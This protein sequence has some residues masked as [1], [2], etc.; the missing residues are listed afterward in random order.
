LGETSI[1]ILEGIPMHNIDPLTQRAWDTGQAILKLEAD[2]ARILVNRGLLV[3]KFQREQMWE[4][5][6]CNTFEEWVAGNEQL[7]IDQLKFAAQFVNVFTERFRIDDPELLI[8]RT[9]KIGSKTEYK[10]VG[11]KKAGY[12]TPLAERLWS[13]VVGQYEIAD[14]NE[15]PLTKWG[16]RFDMADN[17]PTGPLLEQ[18]DAWI[19][20]HREVSFIEAR[21]KCLELLEKAAMLSYSELKEH[22]TAHPIA[23]TKRNGN[24]R[25][26][27]TS[28]Y[29]SIYKG[30]TSVEALRHFE[31][32]DNMLS[33]Y[34]VD[35]YPGE[36]IGMTFYRIRDG[37]T[38]E[39]EEMIEEWEG[40]DE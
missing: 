39:H 2:D 20:N 17:R 26:S 7:N 33:Y 28:V 32:V 10:P 31:T 16:M 12:I 24:H 6:D 1:T 37:G 11:V 4:A 35:Q 21:N 27:T 38:V 29:E 9:L 23:G 13:Q 34:G 5:L 14:D 3:R 25:A 36:R 19:D 30:T 18:R 15:Q 8:G 22:Y 40:E